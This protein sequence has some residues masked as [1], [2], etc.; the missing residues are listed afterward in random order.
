[1]RLQAG[2]YVYKRPLPFQICSDCAAAALI[3]HG[4]T[5]LLTGQDARLP[6]DHSSPH[7]N[8]SVNRGGAIYASN[9]KVY[10]TDTTIRR[11]IAFC[12]DGGLRTTDAE[13]FLSQSS[14]L[15]NEAIEGAGIYAVSCCLTIVDS[16]IADDNST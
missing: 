11:N 4:G 8:S 13:S 5:I 12:L 10:L 6:V 1:M 3:R 7:D 14:L 16:E 2:D 9:G 15:P